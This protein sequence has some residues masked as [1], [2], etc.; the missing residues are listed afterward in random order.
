MNAIRK[1]RKSP[2]AAVFAPPWNDLGPSSPEATDWKIRIGSKWFWIP[3][4]MQACVMSKTPQASPPQKMARK[5]LEEVEVD[6]TRLAPFL[7]GS[8]SYR[9]VGEKMVYTLTP[10]I[11][12][13]QRNLRRKLSIR[14]QQLFRMLPRCFRQLLTTKHPRNFFCLLGCG[15]GTHKR[16]R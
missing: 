2:S 10:I 4:A 11:C 6:D 5:A 7:C 9:R 8:K 16:L 12:A 13:D 15:E 3:Q 14:L 1:C